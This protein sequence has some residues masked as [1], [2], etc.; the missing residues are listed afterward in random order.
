MIQGHGR[1][2]RRSRPIAKKSARELRQGGSDYRCCIP[3]LA[4]FVSPQ[5]IA[6]DGIQNSPEPLVRATRFSRPA[7]GPLTQ[8][9]HFDCITAV[10]Y[11]ALALLI[12]CE[13]SCTTLVTRRDLYSPEPAP[14]S[15]ERSRELA[16]VTT[17]T[18][19]TATTTTTT[20]TETER[21]LASPPPF[22]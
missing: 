11:L 18:S 15:W 12:F 9:H 13:C 16:G 8:E 1:R 17:S 14:D 19:T 6:P 21:A 2:A 20:T 4:G 10:R 7:R 5:S 3:A 22:R